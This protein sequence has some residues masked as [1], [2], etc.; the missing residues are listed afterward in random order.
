MRSI[1]ATCAAVSL[2]VSAYSAGLAAEDKLAP[3]QEKMKT[4][5]AQAGDKKA[6]E[7][8]AFMSSCLNLR[9]GR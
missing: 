9:S 1:L 2:L 8:K 7:R 6:D 5:N 3:Q 4:R